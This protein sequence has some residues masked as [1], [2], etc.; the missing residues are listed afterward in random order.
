MATSA[1]YA[2]LQSARSSYSG[3]GRFGG[4]TRVL[5]GS[6]SASAN[7]IAKTTLSNELESKTQQ[8]NDGVISNEDMRSFLQKMSG[9]T[10]LSASE[11]VQVDNKI[12]DFDAK[13]IETRYEAVYKNAPD[14]SMAKIQ[15]AQTLANYYKEKAG[16]LSPDTPA[17]S[18]ALD[19]AGQWGQVVAS[20]TQQVN[21]QNRALKRAQLFQEVYKQVPNSA[22]EASQKYQAF[23]ELANQAAADGDTVAAA[24]FSAQ[25][26]QAYS[27]AQAT[28]VRE[29]STSNRKALNDFI[30]TTMN[31]YKDGKITG[32][33]AL[34]NLN[35]AD[36]QASNLGE[37]SVSVR[38][39]TLA[40]GI[41][42]DIQKGRTYTT[43]G[44]FGVKSGS[45]GSGTPELLFD[46]ST[47]ELSIGAP[48]SSTGTTSVGTGSKTKGATG[49]K[50]G[51]VPI[52]H[53]DESGP[54]S[55]YRL[56]YEYDQKVKV[57][58]DLFI[59]GQL[60]AKDWTTKLGALS[61]S[62]AQ[63]LGTITDQLGQVDPETELPTSYKT[64]GKGTDKKKVGEII[65]D[66]G[67]QLEDA[68]YSSQKLLSGQIIPFVQL[69]GA[70]NITKGKPS[71]VLRDVKS[72]GKKGENYI[73]D[74][75]G[76]AY[77]LQKTADTPISEAEYLKAE[78]AY[79]DN[80]QQDPLGFLKYTVSYDGNGNAT[81]KKQGGQKYA[82]IY[83]NAG[84][85]IRY[86]YDEASK[87]F[88][89][90]NPNTPSLKA[91]V[92]YAKSQKNTVRPFSSPAEIDKFI[93]QQELQA[94]KANQPIAPF[95]PKVPNAVPLESKTPLNLP[96]VAAKNPTQAIEQMPGLKVVEPVKPNV[97]PEGY[98]PATVPGVS[99]PQSNVAQQIQQGVSSGGLKVNYQSPQQ[100]TASKP[101]TISTSQIK[102]N[103]A[104]GGLSQPKPV[105]VQKQPTIVDQIKK[106]ASGIGTK[107]MSWFK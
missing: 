86:N 70:N 7:T 106:V 24:Q 96:P 4:S 105:V 61:A 30:N 94:Q 19:R 5:T 6:L 83:D 13:I 23:T 9:N 45:G 107:I 60:S 17:A 46:P 26:Q 14:N 58:H 38:L 75:R 93:K 18:D 72:L 33:Q 41:Y 48:V 82:D 71:I 51:A 97:I 87:Q 43:D 32:E 91:Y 11:K 28:S 54:R 2:S 85:S 76:V 8:Y 25:A 90:E 99:A 59:S 44:A 67:T 10:L 102:Q 81:Y 49:S 53:Q 100:P 65:K 79:N 3:Y 101:V 64:N 57:L 37:T 35:A 103:V 77:A 98:K 73:F 47:G 50:N 16:K 66:L 55:L 39:N 74:N 92:N 1:R 56:E 22:E 40:S 95:T 69:S 89:P 29:T 88:L 78:A 80:P 52:N 15:A 36:E 34:A 84:N 68:S 12:R 104:S 27:D 21:K 31:D 62:R 42:T 63:E 20:E